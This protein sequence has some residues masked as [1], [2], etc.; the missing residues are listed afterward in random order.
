MDSGPLSLIT[1]CNQREDVPPK[2]LTQAPP[3]HL[4]PAL[5]GV[6]IFLNVTN[7]VTNC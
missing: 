6:Q 7:Q 1:A 5:T 4:C 2:A 3:Q